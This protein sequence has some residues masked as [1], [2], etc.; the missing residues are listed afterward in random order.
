MF[1]IANA[2]GK[3]NTVTF[4]PEILRRLD[5]NV[6]NVATLVTSNNV[7]NLTN[8]NIYDINAAENLINPRF[9]TV[10]AT[11]IMQDI[12]GICME[13]LITNISIS[14]T[15]RVIGM[16]PVVTIT[17]AQ[18]F[19]DGIDNYL[20]NYCANVESMVRAVLIPEVTLNNEYDVECNVIMDLLGET[21]VMLS[22]GGRPMETFRFATF[23]DSLFS[24]VIT[25]SATQHD[26]ISQYNGVFDTIYADKIGG[27]NIHY[28]QSNTIYNYY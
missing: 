23:A 21:V 1:A 3:F 14:F 15:N 28:D 18:S 7:M 16:D 2:Q 4:T 11:Q 24:P 26:V 27:D 10:M 8:N 6:D 22:I 13:Q 20:L 19:I 17:H 12:V 5:P 9:E 25:N